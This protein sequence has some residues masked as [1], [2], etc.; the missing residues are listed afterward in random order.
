MVNCLVSDDNGVKLRREFFRVS[1]KRYFYEA[2]DSILH[3]FR[4]LLHNFDPR[5]RGGGVFGEL[6]SLI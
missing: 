2:K 5:L 6:S 4:R 3:A 1:V